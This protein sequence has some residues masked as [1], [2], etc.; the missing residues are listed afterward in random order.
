VR[1]C[2]A[3]RK[4]SLLITFRQSNVAVAV[5]MDMHEHCP[6]DKKCI[7]VNSRILSL[8]YTGQVEN[9]LS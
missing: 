1:A 7:F 8:R 9:P 3:L 4:H 2:F 5:A 6:S